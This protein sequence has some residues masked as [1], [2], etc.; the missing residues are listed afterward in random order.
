MRPDC[1]AGLLAGW[2]CPGYDPC[3]FIRHGFA[4]D[5][6]PVGAEGLARMLFV[7]LIA[8]AACVPSGTGSAGSSASGSSVVGR[9]KAEVILLARVGAIRH[10]GVVV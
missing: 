7:L 4:I 9:I 3:G 10:R 6:R 2:G 5:K 1:E 8:Q